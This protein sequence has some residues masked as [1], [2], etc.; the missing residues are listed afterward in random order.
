MTLATSTKNILSSNIY[1]C[2][3]FLQHPISEYEL[4]K[5]IV[6]RIGVNMI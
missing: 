4:I 6:H 2:M 1:N 3:S 5:N